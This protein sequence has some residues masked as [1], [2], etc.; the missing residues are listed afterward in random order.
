MR[1]AAPRKDLLSPTLIAAEAPAAIRVASSPGRP[2]V[3]ISDLSIRLAADEWQ[4]HWVVALRANDGR[5]CGTIDRF[6]AEG[7]DN[8][9]ALSTTQRRPSGRYNARGEFFVRKGRFPPPTGRIATGR[10]APARL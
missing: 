6:P 7:R 1:Q 2:S 9:A 8:A 10:S 5:S 3:E 4:R